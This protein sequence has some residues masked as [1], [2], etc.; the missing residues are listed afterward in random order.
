MVVESCRES[1]RIVLDCTE[2][3]LAWFGDGC[4]RGDW[5]KARADDM[6]RRRDRAGS[7]WAGS[8]SANAIVMTAVEQS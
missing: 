2:L 1:F 8:Q 5:P 7:L 6:V 3:A 4:D